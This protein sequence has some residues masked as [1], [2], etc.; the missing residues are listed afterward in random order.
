[1]LLPELKQYAKENGIPLEYGMNKAR[2][3]ARLTEQ[4]ALL[5]SGEPLSIKKLP[6]GRRPGSSRQIVEDKQSD[7]PKKTAPEKAAASESAAYSVSSD[8]A[9]LQEERVSDPICTPEI[10]QA[11][12]IASERAEEAPSAELLEPALDTSIPARLDQPARYEHARNAVWSTVR[13]RRSETDDSAP[14]PVDA[15]APRVSIDDPAAIQRKRPAWSAQDS[16]PAPTRLPPQTRYNRPISANDRPVYVGTRIAPPQSGLRD[17]GGTDDRLNPQAIRPVPARTDAAPRN[18]YIS[19]ADGA[20]DYGGY[21]ERAYGG[22]PDAP[23]ARFS[24]TGDRW[25]EA[26]RSAPPRVAYE[27]RYPREQSAPGPSLPDLLSSGECSE[28]EGILELHPDGYG[29]LRGDNYQSSPND[30]Y[31]SIAQIRRFGLKNG[32][33]IAGKTRPI[34]E[35]ERNT[36]LLFITSINDVPV[37]QATRRIPFENLTPVYPNKRLTLENETNKSDLAIRVIDFIA[38]IGK[39][40]RALIVAPPKAGK[41]ILLK[42]I[43]NAVS[44][45]YPETELI[46]L[47]I[48]ERPEEVT[49]IKRSITSGEVVYSTFDELPENHTRVAELVIERA[50]RLVECGKDVVILLDSLTRL[51]RAYNA[52]APQTGRAMSGG[53]APGVLHKP[54]RF[55]GAARNVEGGGSLTIIATTLVETGSRMDDVIYEEFKG[56]GNMEIHLDRKLS[57]KRIF[58]AIDLAK[59]GTRREEMLLSA[60]ELDGVFTI[61]KILSSSNMADATEQLISMLAKTPSNDAFFLRLKEWMA[62]WEKEGYSIG[63]RG[64]R[65]MND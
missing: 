46:I 55:F 38:P 4:S 58:P 11:D 10:G 12:N 23:R 18:R 32:D 61:R 31:L 42:K 50:Q 59:S 36:A 8:T 40:Q 41:T 20:P 56:T 64:L 43:A 7:M 21:G 45:N 13:A 51:S 39:G 25:Q 48:D 52:T 37:D 26:P 24:T 16:I 60:K 49:D 3:V 57:E 54:K 44:T 19:S 6:R 2:I 34:R 15:D 14:P 1:M 29:F 47:L 53:L 9:Q 62:I 30:V 65:V 63:G 35:G 22:Q 33:K 28:G 5:A 27:P 17:Y